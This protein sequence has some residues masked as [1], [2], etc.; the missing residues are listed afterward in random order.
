MTHK[1]IYIII[2]NRFECSRQG[3]KA[4]LID[5]IHA[6]FELFDKEN[7]YD[8]GVYVL[9]KL[10]D[11]RV[12]SLHLENLGVKLNSINVKQAKYLGVPIGGPYKP[13]GYRY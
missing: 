13:E 9:P 2:G 11:E 6:R 10:L 8:V 1:L 5:E 7:D 12:A 3:S 4:S